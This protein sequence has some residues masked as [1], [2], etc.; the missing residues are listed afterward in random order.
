L[1]VIF[2]PVDFNQ[3]RASIAELI[4]TLPPVCALCHETSGFYVSLTNWVVSHVDKA[5]EATFRMESKV[6][7]KA[8]IE[9]YG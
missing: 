8:K 1:S 5:H 3:M 6:Q 9:G 7:A 2:L 4:H